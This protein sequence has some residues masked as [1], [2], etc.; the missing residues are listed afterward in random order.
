MASPQTHRIRVFIDSSVLYAAALS[1][2]GPAREL[3]LR[4][5]RGECDLVI[6]PL[7]LEETER[8]L[9]DKAPHA[10][11]PFGAFRD[12]LGA[13]QVNPS[14]ASIK[15][16]ARSLRRAHILRRTPGTPQRLN[17]HWADRHPA[18]RGR[19]PADDERRR[20]R[21]RSVPTGG[22]TAAHPL[23]PVPGRRPT[24]PADRP[25]LSVE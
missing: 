20:G 5:I 16:V 23:L 21:G 3:I 22:C 12:V 7:V 19:Q 15:R 18:R 9:E 13:R 25:V 1:A 8:N 17:Y 24:P 6:S 14:K 4:G 2:T 10:L 11:G